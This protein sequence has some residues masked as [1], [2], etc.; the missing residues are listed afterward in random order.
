[1]LVERKDWT[2]AAER[3]WPNVEPVGGAADDERG[4]LREPQPDRLRQGERMLASLGIVSGSAPSSPCSSRNRYGFLEVA[5]RMPSADI[6]MC[7]SPIT[8]S[9]AGAATDRISWAAQTSM[10]PPK[11]MEARTPMT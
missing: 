5:L 3:T 11:A 9:L 2:S 6:R 7:Q 1:M 8:R 10:T 4:P